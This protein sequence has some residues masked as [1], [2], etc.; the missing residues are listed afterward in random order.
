MCTWNKNNRACTT[1]WTTLRVLDQNKKVFKDSGEVKMPELTFWNPA[2]SA[3]M[4]K[5]QA[6][7]LANQIDNVFIMIR[8]AKYEEN[9]TKEKAITGIT[10]ALINEENTICNLAEIVDADY[11]FWGEEQL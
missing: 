11:L 7:S 2:A 1:T 8:K 3:E 9:I 5:L 4:R 10:N 6:A